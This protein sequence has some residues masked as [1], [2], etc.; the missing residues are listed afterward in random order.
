MVNARKSGQKSKPALDN[1]GSGEMRAGR[2]KG[3]QD[4]GGLEKDGSLAADLVGDIVQMPPEDWIGF[5]DS[6]SRQHEGWLA[7]IEITLGKD[8]TTELR[9]RPLE[10][11]SCDHLSARDKIYLSFEGGDGEHLTHPVRNP[12]K[13][14]FRRDLEGAHEGIDINSADGSVTSIRFRIP[15]NPETLDGLLSETNLARRSANHLTGRRK[16]YPP[17]GSD[18][19]TM[20][21]QIP[22]GGV[23]LEGELTIPTNAKGVILFAHG[24]GSSR[25]SHRDQ[26]V[27]RV[28]GKASFATL[29]M[30]LLTLEEERRDQRSAELRFDIELLARRLTAATRWLKDLSATANLHIGYFGASTGAAAALVAAA[31]LTGKVSA[32]VSR[33]G[34]PDLAGMA[35]HKV[36]APTLLIVGENDPEVLALNREAYYA[37]PSEKKMEIVPKATHL[38]EERGALERVAQLARD[39]FDTHLASPGQK[40]KAA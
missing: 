14:V 35:L 19:S 10:G 21:F 24:S 2:G 27:A 12:M 38:F 5:F 33:G 9:D 8:K 13:V 26:Y 18:P 25:H 11:I 36:I 30:D 37:I 20:A 6:F 7:S 40:S 23:F 31:R 32:I 17:L 39:W 34:R 15:A 28:L 16:P 3:P 1:V 4:L 22:A 29:L